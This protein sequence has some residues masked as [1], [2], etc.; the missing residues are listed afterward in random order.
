MCSNKMRLRSN[1]AF[2]YLKHGDY[3]CKEMNG[4]KITFEFKIISAVPVTVSRS[5][6]L[7]RKKIRNLL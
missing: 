1:S 6:S 7:I 5:K 4:T 2:S 3:V